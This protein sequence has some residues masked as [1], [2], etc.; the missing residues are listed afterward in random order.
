MILI[1]FLLF[2]PTQV[3]HLHADGESKTDET[4]EGD[5]VEGGSDRVQEFEFLVGLVHSGGWLDV[6]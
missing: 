2:Y 1:Q 3:I 5:E 4:G 6:S